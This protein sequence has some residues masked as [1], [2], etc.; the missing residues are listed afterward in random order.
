MRNI[1]L[2]LAILS[3]YSC[4]SIEKETPSTTSHVMND[5]KISG[6]LGNVKKKTTHTYRD[7]VNKDGKW[8]I[9]EGPYATVIT[10]YN[11]DGRLTQSQIFSYESG[12]MTLT[13]KSIYEF[14]NGLP[15]S[16][17]VFENNSLKSKESIQYINDNTYK[18]T[19]ENNPSSQ[20][21]N[22]LR[23]NEK[24]FISTHTYAVDSISVKI[25]TINS[26]TYNNKG[27]IISYQNK[28]TY[29]QNDKPLEGIDMDYES[30]TTS[31]VI[32]YDS[33]GNITEELLTTQSK[34]KIFSEIR[35]FEYEYY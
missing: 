27:N 24:S 3:I 22:E 19:Y 2:T 32:S 9:D 12:K 28:R 25:V 23:D 14:Q 26:Q 4:N 15:V 33:K 29:T 7:P 18:I 8:L 1:L 10:H 6:L 35:K 30:T 20:S 16:C 31:G 13:H 34:E 21:I 11:K 5:Y 17:S